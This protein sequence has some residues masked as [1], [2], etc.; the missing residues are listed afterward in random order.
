MRFRFK[1]KKLCS[2]YTTQKGAA[3]YPAEVVASFFRVM[4]IIYSASDE[5]DFYQFKQLHY[6]KL[7]GQKSRPEK[8]SMRLH[9]RWR[10]ILCIET[11]EHGKEV[12]VLE[13]SNHYE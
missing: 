6:E 1:T 10:L 3:D 12:L 13:I 8:R 9:G 7:K 2:L 11:D 4:S 5:S